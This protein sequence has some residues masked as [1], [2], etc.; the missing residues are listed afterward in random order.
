M[1]EKNKSSACR[2]LRQHKHNISCEVTEN[3]M[4]DKFRDLMEEEWQTQYYAE[5]EDRP[6]KIW[7][8]KVQKDTIKLEEQTEKTANRK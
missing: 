2:T 7:M 1:E 6:R 5:K 3:K 4:T 8:N